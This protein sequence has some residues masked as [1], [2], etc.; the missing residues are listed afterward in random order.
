[1]GGDLNARAKTWDKKYNVRGHLLEEWVANNELTVMN[2]GKTEMCVRVQGSSMVDVTLGTET[3]MK[4]FETWR[5]DAN[6]ETLSDHRYIVIQIDSKDRM[7]RYSRGM[8]FPRWNTSKINK[9]WFAAS[10]LGGN[11]L[12]EHKID[13]LIGKGEIGKADYAL[14]RIFSDACDNA[15]TRTK[16]GGN[17]K[18]NKVYWWNNE[19]I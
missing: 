12:L 4:V 8:E 9:D 11:W 17:I 6:T 13:S 19:I 10:I 15:M 16:G 3:A 18:R 5:V 14:K 2:D 7:S 1:M